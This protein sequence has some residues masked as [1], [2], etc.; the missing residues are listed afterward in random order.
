MPMFKYEAITG[1]QG[2]MVEINA[3]YIYSFSAALLI[4]IASLLAGILL[5]EE[6]RLLDLLSV[7]CY[8]RYFNLCC[9]ECQ[10]SYVSHY[11][12]HYSFNTL[13]L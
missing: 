12:I 10:Y 4:L 7:I 3:E 13:V 2:K 8:R 6:N 5:D 1:K 11:H 9:E